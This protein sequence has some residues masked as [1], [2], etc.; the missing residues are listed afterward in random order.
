MCDE[1]NYVEFTDEIGKSIGDTLL[2]Q[3]NSKILYSMSQGGK[4]VI[5]ILA[6][7]LWELRR[8]LA[9][10]KIMILNFDEPQL[11]DLGDSVLC[12]IKCTDK[13][14]G[15]EHFGVKE[16]AK[17]GQGRNGPYKIQAPFEQAT[18]KAQRNAVCALV[19]KSILAYLRK[20]GQAVSPS[21]KAFSAYDDI[22]HDFDTNSGASTKTTYVKPTPAPA[23]P[24]DDPA[25][26][27]ARIEAIAAQN[28]AKLTPAEI[29]LKIKEATGKDVMF[30]GLTTVDDLKKYTALLKATPAKP[31]VKDEKPKAK[32]ASSP[33]EI[34]KKPKT[35]PVTE[36]E[37]PEEEIVSSSGV[38]DFLE[39]M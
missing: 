33:S 9:V 39:D 11:T 8:I 3:F 19:P 38:M 6:N 26:R 31:V 14:S 25:I 5:D 36:A 28:E 13:V 21:D 4:T 29:K 18:S 37:P 34:E 1:N 7:P 22:D 24:P 12:K 17:T 16:Q 15:I 2:K 35:K 30:S 23:K 32:L 27:E 20:H 10:K